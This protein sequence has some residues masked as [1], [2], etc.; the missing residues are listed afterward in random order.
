MAIT[1]CNGKRVE[2]YD[3]NRS[4]N[5]PEATAAHLAEAHET[6]YEGVVLS[7]HERNGYDD[8][9]FY[10]MVWDEE[11]GRVKSV[12]YATTR[13]WTYHN[14][15]SVDATDEVR[16]KAV[17]WKTKMLFDSYVREELVTV[18]EGDMIRSTT[19]RGKNKGVEAV[20]GRFVKGDYGPQVIVEVDGVRRYLDATRVERVN[21]VISPERGRELA[22]LAVY[23]AERELGVKAGR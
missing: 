17:A 14:G 10:A 16:A 22:E 15:A 1:I 20:A 19:T 3:C 11:T 12:E 7:L 4:D 6:S 13:G 21:P 18:H 9:D 2:G 8:S 5:S 23:R